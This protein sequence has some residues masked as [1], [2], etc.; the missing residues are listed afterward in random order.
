[1]KSYPCIGGPLDGQF[2][3]DDDQRPKYHSHNGEFITTFPKP[4]DE[5]FPFNRAGSHTRTPSRV[6][7]HKS[8]LQ[9]ERYNP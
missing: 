9:D 5:Y 8:I 7:I 2:I 1:M 6:Y 3:S 4:Y